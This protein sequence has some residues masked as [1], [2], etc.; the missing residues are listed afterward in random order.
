RIEKDITAK[1]D[2]EHQA[3]ENI[4]AVVQKILVGAKHISKCLDDNALLVCDLQLLITKQGDISVIDPLDVVSRKETETNRYTYTSLLDMSKQS[5]PDFIQQIMASKRLLSQTASWCEKVI[6]LKTQQELIDFVVKGKEPVMPAR[7][8]LEHFRQKHSPRANG[9]TENTPRNNLPRK[10]I[11][12]KS[13]PIQ[14]SEVIVAIPQVQ[15]NHSALIERARN[16]PA[17]PL[18]LE[19]SLNAQETTPN[20][21]PRKVVTQRTSAQEM[22]SPSKVLSEQLNQFYFDVVSSNAKK[23][24]ILDDESTAAGASVSKEHVKVRFNI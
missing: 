18:D 23:R 7:S 13:I 4:K 15:P 22:P 19:F 24:L 11:S 10:P 5:N 2:Q 6:A 8:M 17:L 21:S 1:I 9:D 16:F 3:L 12:V 14:D 20:T